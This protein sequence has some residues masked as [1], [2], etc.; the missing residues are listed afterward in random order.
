[1]NLYH[2][3]DK[4][5]PISKDSEIIRNITQKYKKHPS[6]RSWRRYFKGVSYFSFQPIS[7][8]EVIRVVK[9]LKHSEA[10]SGDIPTKI[11]KECK[12]TFDIITACINKAIETGNCPDSFKMANVR[13]VFKKENPLD[14]SN[15]RRVSIMPLISKVYQ[16]VIYNQLSE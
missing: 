8:D 12:F 9:N 1:M 6:I 11:L 16:R 7:M 2:W 15:Y 3:E 14:K 4:P 10:V 13:P 5:F